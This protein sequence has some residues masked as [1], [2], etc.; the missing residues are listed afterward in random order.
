MM[1]RRWD[2][3]VSAVIAARHPMTPEERAD[4]VRALVGATQEGAF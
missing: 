4:L 1:A 3:A 2:A